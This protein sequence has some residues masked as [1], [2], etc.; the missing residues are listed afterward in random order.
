MSDKNKD[1]SSLTAS[2]ALNIGTTDNPYSSYGLLAYINAVVDKFPSLK[3]LVT[4]YNINTGVLFTPQIISL[5]DGEISRDPGIIYDSFL[6]IDLVNIYS[7]E[8]TGDIDTVYNEVVSSIV[9][10]RA[11]FKQETVISETALDPYTIIN[12]E[13]FSELLHSNKTMVAVYLYILTTALF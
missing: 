13:S 2:G 10:T 7:L 8:T 11:I 5:L 9:K 1:Y 6:L 4:S 12:I 3:S